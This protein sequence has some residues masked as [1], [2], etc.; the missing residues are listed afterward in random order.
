MPIMETHFSRRPLPDNTRLESPLES[1]IYNLL[2]EEQ[3]LPR[4]VILER[5]VAYLRTHREDL[6]GGNADR[7][8]ISRILGTL[9]QRQV[10]QEIHGIPLRKWLRGMDIN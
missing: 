1:V 3:L 8:T 9:A 6:P 2:S 10:L 7:D 4:S 5:V